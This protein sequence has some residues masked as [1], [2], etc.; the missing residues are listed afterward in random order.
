MPV[1]LTTEREVDVWLNAPT[2]VALELQ[3]PLASGKLRI[4]AR[5]DRTDGA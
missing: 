5:G 2:P 4:V 3:K 1:I